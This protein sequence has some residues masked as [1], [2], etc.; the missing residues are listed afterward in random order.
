M[1]DMSD[2]NVILE[3]YGP[4]GLIAFGLVVAVRAYLSG[5]ASGLLGTFFNGLLKGQP[6]RAETYG[7]HALGTTSVVDPARKLI[8]LLD[9]AL[10]RVQANAVPV[11]AK[12]EPKKEGDV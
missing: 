1:P 8:A 10:V 7:L 9:A 2:L 4:I 11:P 5:Q 6:T 12:T 3:Q